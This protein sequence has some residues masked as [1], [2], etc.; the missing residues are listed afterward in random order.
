MIGIIDYEVGNLFN[1]QT[2]LARVGLD[3]IIT[4]DPNKLAEVDAIILPGVGAVR[5][6]MENLQKFDLIEV[7]H[8]NVKAGKLFF[9]ICLGMQLLFEKSY[10][11][12]EYGCLSLMEGNIIPFDTKLKIP[13]MGWNTLSIRKESPIAEGI[14][15]KYVYFVHSYLLDPKFSEN[16]IAETEYDGIVPAIVG[17]DNVFG[18]QFHPEKSGDTGYKIL[19]NMKKMIEGA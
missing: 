16:I 17:K 9:G 6:A 18:M 11:G 14:E 19:Q 1:V 8:K 13:H 15:D 2:G 10:E 5:D 4:R 12:G 7:I 3:S